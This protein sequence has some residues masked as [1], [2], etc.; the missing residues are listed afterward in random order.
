[1]WAGTDRL[2]WLLR[3]VS[4]KLAMPGFQTLNLR[5]KFFTYENIDLM[6]V[7]PRVLL[8]EEKSSFIKY[9]RVCQRL[10]KRWIQKRIH[11]WS[12]GDKQA[13]SCL[14]R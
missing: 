7:Q 11:L 9:Y 6:G 4:L 10:K 13:A 2:K 14:A 12:R 5:L 1:M 8:A 3:G